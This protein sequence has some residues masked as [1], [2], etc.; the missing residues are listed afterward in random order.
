MLYNKVLAITC[1][2]LALSAPAFAAHHRLT[3]EWWLTTADRS[4]EFS[5]QKTDLAF[6]PPSASAKLTDSQGSTTP[7]IAVDPSTTFQTIDGFGYCLTGGSAQHL[8]N[9]SADA[10]KALLEELFGQDGNDLGVSY[11]RVTIGSSDLNDHVFSYDDIP[12]GQTD[13]SLTQF[14]IAED[15]KNVIPILQQIL[16]IN[17]RITILASPWSAPTWMKT[18]DDV[19][20]GELKEE[21]YPV[22]AQYLARYVQEMKKRGI[23][24]DAITPQN[25]PM[26]TNNTPSMR[27]TAEAEEKFVKEDLG[28]VFQAA[29]LST[30][31]IVWDHN[32]DLPN[33]PLTILDDPDAA[34]YVD[35]SGFHLY[36]GKIT[37]LSTVHFAHPEK[38][39]Y[40][41]EE[42]VVDNW[43]FNPSK[44]VSSVLI[45]ATRNWSR[46][47]LL[48]N[49]AANSA[50]QPHT[51]NGGCPICEGAVTIDGDDVKRNV[52]YYAVAHFSKFVSPGSTRID[53]T[54]VD[55]LPNVAF[56]TP[57]GKTVLVV[58]NTTDAAQT[59]QVACD[60]QSIQPTLPG[61]AVATFVW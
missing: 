18:N 56:K 41:T 57:D 46:N 19:K 4:S 50:M 53:S 60:G 9:M 52:A 40:F 31:I 25:E 3:A 11:L 30:K 55:G 49:L 8:I 44:P 22:Y 58:A 13:P 26:N 34:K 14:T 5:R 32:C 45:G 33:Y 17:P 12:A 24:V 10:R 47:V 51:D 36:R 54:D 6:A 29:G 43:G 1:V 28:P 61:H 15:E 38:N 27:M 48:W 16:A 37:A 59:F 20:G 2:A 39:V 21:D 42:M 7:T 23:T 35:G